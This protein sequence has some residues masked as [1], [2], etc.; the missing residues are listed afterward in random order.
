MAFDIVCEKLKGDSCGYLE[1]KICS[2]SEAFFRSIS[3]KL[4]LF[5]YGAL[6]LILLLFI[7]FLFMRITVI[8]LVR[9][10]FSLSFLINS[11]SCRLRLYLFFLKITGNDRAVI[12]DLRFDSNGVLEFENVWLGSAGSVSM[13]GIRVS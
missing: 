7:E 8:L 13:M 2:N 9:I 6:S 1:L 5:R 12:H 4:I 11:M 3:V 10:I